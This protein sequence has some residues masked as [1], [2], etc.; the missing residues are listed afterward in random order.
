MKGTLAGLDAFSLILCIHATE[1]MAVINTSTRIFPT[2]KTFCSKQRIRY[3]VLFLLH[4]S[5]KRIWTW[6]RRYSLVEKNRKNYSKMMSD[7]YR[8]TVSV[9][10]WIT[11]IYAIVL[12]PAPCHSLTIK[13]RRCLQTTCSCEYVEYQFQ[14]VIQLQKKKNSVIIM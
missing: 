4:L 5:L 13:R 12:F 10:I 8:A 9:V 11:S 14:H 2:P 7:E 3:P 1:L 6:Y